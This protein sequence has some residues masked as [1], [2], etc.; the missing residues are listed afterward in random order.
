MGEAVV[1][2]RF[3]G[4]DARGGDGRRSVDTYNS[5]ASSI[6]PSALINTSNNASCAA[7][8]NIEDNIASFV[9][10]SSSSTIMNRLLS[11]R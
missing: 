4:G 3:V 5:I 1:L 11:F 10:V 8:V 2:W 6:F 9:S 7:P